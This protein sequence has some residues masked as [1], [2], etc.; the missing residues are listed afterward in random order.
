[1]VLV[2]DAAKSITSSDGELIQPVC[3]GDRWGEWAT[4][5]RAVQG[6]VCAVVVVEGFEFAQGVQQVGPGSGSGCGRAVQ[7]GRSG[8][9]VP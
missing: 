4:G 5:S 9:S 2:E 7:F 6:A 1:M 8:S 3:F